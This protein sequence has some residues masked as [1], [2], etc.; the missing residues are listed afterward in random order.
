MKKNA[1]LPIFDMKMRRFGGSQG[2]DFDELPIGGGSGCC[3]FFFFL[4]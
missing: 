4:I 2:V 3:D 1:I